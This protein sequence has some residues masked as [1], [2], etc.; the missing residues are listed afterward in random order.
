[1]FGPKHHPFSN[2]LADI[3]LEPDMPQFTRAGRRWINEA[4]GLFGMT[5]KIAEQPG[6]ISWAIQS[7]DA[8]AAI[9]D[10]FIHNPAFASKAYLYETWESELEEEA[11]LP[12]DAPVKKAD[13]LAELADACGMPRE[14]FLAA[15]ERYNRAAAA[16]AD[17]E[18]S[19]DGRFLVPIGDK[20]PY[21]AILGKRFSEASLGGLM[22]DG[23]C[24]VLRNDGS[25]IPGLYGVGDATSAMHRKGKLAVISELT[26]AMASAYTSGGDAAAYTDTL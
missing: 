16:G 12:I 10:R 13:T 2:V 23:R 21:Y 5:A 7:R 24:R 8:I 26:W 22:V 18:F 1:M 9:A 19:K 3:A 20:G 14:T 11:A 6:E 15:V 25:P 4:D 17:D